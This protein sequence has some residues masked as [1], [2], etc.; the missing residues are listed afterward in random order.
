MGR[1]GSF[2]NTDFIFEVYGLNTFRYTSSDYWAHTVT[3]YI[4][5][6]RTINLPRELLTSLHCG[7]NHFPTMCEPERGNWSQQ[8]GLREDTL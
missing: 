3:S 5:F 7:S 1:E 8:N 4:N 2:Y 6:L